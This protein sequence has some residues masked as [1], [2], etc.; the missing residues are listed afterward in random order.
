MNRQ[1]AMWYAGLAGVSLL[2]SATLLQLSRNVSALALVVAVVIAFVLPPVLIW[3]AQRMGYPIGRS[4]SCP[5]CGMEMPFIRRPTSAKQAVW[6]GYTCPKCGTE[7][8]AAGRTL[9]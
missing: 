9:A 1:Y 4:V 3:I 7:M 5:N 6:G 2:I 8:D